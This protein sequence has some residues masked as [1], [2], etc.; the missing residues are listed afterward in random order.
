MSSLGVVISDGVGFRNFVL[1]D[2]II[3]AQKQFSKVVILSCLPESAYN[4]LNINCKIIE[5]DVFEERFITWIFRKAK[6][7]AHLQLHKNESFGIADNLNSNYS[8]V[9]TVRGYFSRFLFQWTKRFHSESW[10]QRYN[11]LQQLTYIF[12]LQP[13]RYKEILKDLDLDLIFF[14]HQRPPYIAPII[15]VTQKLKIK[16]A[17]FIFSWDNLASKGRM[18]GNFEFYLVWSDLMKRELIQYYP[19]IKPENIIIVGTPQFE[20]Y[21]LDRYGYSKED[22]LTRF[23]LKADSLTLLFS[24]GDVSTSPNDP[25][26]IDVIARAISQGVFKRPLNFIVRTSP[27]EPPERFKNIAEK[28]SFIRWNYPQWTQ[29]RAM[30]AESWSQRVP[31][32]QDMND[33]K[34]ILQFSDLNVNMLSTMSL[35]IMLFGK[36]VVNIIFGNGANGLADDQRFLNYAHLK[37]LADS[38]ATYIAKTEEELI[39]AISRAIACPDE[40][41]QFRHNL[42]NLEIGQPLTGTSER[43]SGTLYSLCS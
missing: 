11:Y 35:D 28:Y 7:L 6:E 41:D 32:I 1:S 39:E 2:F 4:G 24:C 10:I 38:N 5:L 31:S 21:V 23:N 12:Y 18:A 16:M 43:I 27:A 14:S 22:F 15:Y 42:L 34:T 20:P 8:R 26:Y 17:T 9:S 36:P 30:H 25:F 3:E 33:L 19:K 13:K 29:T 37:Y 40:K